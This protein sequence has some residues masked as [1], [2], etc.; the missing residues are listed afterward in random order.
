[1]R[2]DPRKLHILYYSLSSR[3]ASTSSP[4]LPTTN[5]S[6]QSSGPFMQE[7]SHLH[8]KEETCEKILLDESMA[9]YDRIVEDLT[10]NT[11]VNMTTRIELSSSV[12][13]Y[14]VLEKYTEGSAAF[15]RS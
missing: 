4:R 3:K 6:L 7:Q 5:Y 14:D 8:Y 2:R 11:I 12:S 9:I 10:N 13:A 1:M 15:T